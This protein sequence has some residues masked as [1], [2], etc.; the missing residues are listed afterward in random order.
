MVKESSI[1]DEVILI[2]V[3]SKYDGTDFVGAAS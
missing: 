1:N 3:E 2:V